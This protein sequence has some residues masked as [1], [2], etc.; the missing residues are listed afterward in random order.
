MLE[1]NQNYF[2]FIFYDI[3]IYPNYFLVVFKIEDQYYQWSS[4]NKLEDIKNPIAWIEEK[5]K[6]KYIFV[7]WNNQNYDRL[8]LTKF[9][10]LYNNVSKE[11]MIQ[12]L[13]KLSK[14]L[15]NNETLNRMSFF[16]R[17][18]HLELKTNRVDYDLM[19]YTGTYNIGLRRNL[20]KSL[21]EMGVLIHHPRLETL[22]FDPEQPLKE[23]EKDII[24]KYCYNDVD[25]VYSLF[26]SYFKDQVEN[27]QLLIKEFNVPLVA[28]GWTDATIVANILV[29]GKKQQEKFK[30]K[31]ER[32]F[33]YK[34]FVNFDFKSKELQEVL[35]TYKRNNL[36]EKETSEEKKSLVI[37]KEM[38]GLECSF[39]LGGLHASKKQYKAENLIELD[40]ASYY[41]F[42]M[43][44]YDLLPPQVQ[45]KKTYY[46]MIDN[47]LVTKKKNPNLATAQKVVLNMVFG[48]T[49]NK[50]SKLYDF[51]ATYNI[52]ITGQLLIAKLAEM[53]YLKGYEVVYIN[54]DGIIFKDR[55]DIEYK[56]VAA[57]WEKN[58]NFMLEETKIKKIFLKDVNNY[59]L[60]NEKG[61]TKSKG[62]FDY[63][64][65]KKNNA[66]ARVVWK[67]VENFLI[68]DIKIEDTIYNEKDN[69]LFDYLL[70]HRFS[71][72]SFN[73]THIL[74]H[75][76]KNKTQFN[77]YVRYYLSNN[78]Y[79]EI[80]AF[81]KNYVNGKSSYLGKNVVPIF[82]IKNADIPW[83]LDKSRYVREAY[84]KLKELSGKDY[85]QSNLS[86]QP[87]LEKGF[88]IED[89]EGA[90]GK[91][92][93][94]KDFINS[95]ITTWKVKCGPT[96]E[97]L[98]LDV[99]NPK[100]Y[101]A[102]LLLNNI[103][104]EDF[105][106]Y[107]SKFTL[108]DVFNQKCRFKVIFKHKGEPITFSKYNKAVEVF[109]T[110][111]GKS[112]A[113]FGEKEKGTK[114]NFSGEVKQLRLDVN[115]FLEKKVKFS[116]ISKDYTT[117]KIIREEKPEEKE[118]L[119]LQEKVNIDE[120]RGILK[121]INPNLAKKL[122]IIQKE[123][124]LTFDCFGKEHRGKNFARAFKNDGVYL[125]T[126][127]GS[128]CNEELKEFNKRIRE[129]LATTH[130]F[131]A[132]RG[133]DEIDPT[134]RVNVFKA[135]MGWGKTRRATEEIAK[136]LNNKSK[137]LIIFPNKANIYNAI[138]MFETFEKVSIKPYINGGRVAI[139]TSENKENKDHKKKLL[140]ADVI[141]SHHQYFQNVGHFLSFYETSYE[142]LERPNQKVII[143]EADVFLQKI[144][145]LHIKSSYKYKKD[146]FNG[147]LI[148][149]KDEEA[150][151]KEQFLEK[152][153]SKE[154]DVL[155]NTQSLRVGLTHDFY[156]KGTEEISPETNLKYIGL[157]P[158]IQNK[159]NYKDK[160]E[161]T[162]Y[163]IIRYENKSINNV[164]PHK[165][166]ELSEIED[167]NEFVENNL[168]KRC[169]WA[170]IS[171]NWG[172]DHKRKNIGNV[173]VS[174]YHYEMLDK[175]LKQPSQVIL[176]SATFE[177]YHFDIIENSINDY[178]YKSKEEP[179]GVIENAIVVLRS[180]KKRRSLSKALQV[181]KDYNVKSLFFLPTRKDCEISL[182]GDKQSELWW[183]DNGTYNIK[184]N[185]DNKV[186]A[187]RNISL[188]ALESPVSRGYN[189]IEEV[190]ERYDGFELLWFQQPPISP[191]YIKHYVNRKGE[192]IDYSFDSNLNK[193]IQAIG[194]AFRK[195]KQKLTICLNN[196]PDDMYFDIIKWLKG[197][198]TARIV[199]QELTMSNVELSIARLNKEGKEALKDIE[200]VKELR[201]FE[202]D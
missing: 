133:F 56:N 69:N 82:E 79:N 36:P 200:I 53:L 46:K 119:L 59:L 1:T 55:G 77:Q 169:K 124:M 108:E 127:F 193:I 98:A 181:A 10:N 73:D 81:G 3:E 148:W 2:N 101:G 151:T 45:N 115:L 185:R 186:V 153:N 19:K 176:T 30:S 102:K 12:E 91:F 174:F 31:I 75:K 129:V 96:S 27:K 142:I 121:E 13:F 150:Y 117:N 54:T 23:N 201:G 103:T 147:T 140:S 107:D 99:D 8:M 157:V 43:K 120:F 156:L 116:L 40:V 161:N 106:V 168:V 189:Y 58:F 122:F 171:K 159:L 90:Q 173:I 84:L 7:G 112:V 76:T 74:D 136:A 155:A 41:P 65:G 183:N 78:S 32:F 51:K 25:I 131:K 80:K 202:N 66:F 85:S 57:E 47:R 135:P 139:Y 67:A 14:S 111:K 72:T 88:K 199:E 145:T 137:L 128:V 113:V 167:T 198:T 60:I 26:K 37:E 16:K 44:N 191:N 71:K 61:E 125:I 146:Y 48:T 144:S 126:C 180:E 28:F 165:I 93:L 114:Y 178:G 197:Y 196:F 130:I 83:D 187:D 195:R 118:K 4:E 166:V 182:I 87:L 164:L 179:V 97:Y 138:T 39:G 158:M 177:R 62:S 15:I 38:F 70:Y 172:D 141:I 160:V 192:L 6:E 162:P 68:R 20:Y 63:S 175:I 152:L 86:P 49:R 50:H 104:K 18:E 190:N 94:T 11:V 17:E 194:R 34:P 163:E 89:L 29:P 100:V 33:N 105:I 170:V 9:L 95:D 92:N 52:T 109:Y 134:K 24:E 21:K 154:I 132:T 22:P 42:I 110:K 184:Y 149:K 188:V 143:D 5:V 123:K 35:E 64:L